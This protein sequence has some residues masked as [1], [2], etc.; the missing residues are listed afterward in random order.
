MI[1]KN[2]IAFT[3]IILIFISTNPT[4]GYAL[5]GTFKTTTDSIQNFSNYDGNLL[6]VDATASWCTSCDAQLHNL[7][8]VYDSVDDTIQ[9]VTLSI[10][11]SDTVPKIIE[12]KNRF[13]SPWTFGLDY[14]SDF[15]DKHPV[16]VLP[17]LFLFSEDGFLIK[18][19]ESITPASVILSKLNEN[20][21]TSFEANFDSGESR[22]QGNLLDE[23]FGS[24]TFQLFA[25]L[26]IVIVLYLVFVPSKPNPTGSESKGQ[27]DKKGSKKEVSREKK[28]VN[29]SLKKSQSKSKVNKISNKKV[30][31]NRNRRN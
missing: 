29:E 7:Q 12:L 1:K 23:L 22:Y 16:N 27:V 10:D 17:T 6:I 28:K 31:R 4:L 8:D 9:I 18:K 24:F 26:A 25:S 5:S 30:R 11:R 3:I 15:M 19:W 14:Q 20:I 21:E 2:F 13:S